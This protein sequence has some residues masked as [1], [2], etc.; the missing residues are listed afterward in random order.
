MNTGATPVNAGTGPALGP[1]EP[2][3]KQSGTRILAITSKAI[4]ISLL[5]LSLLLSA[6][7]QAKAPSP[8]QPIPDELLHSVILDTVAPAATPSYGSTLKPSFSKPQP[9]KPP[10]PPPK[11]ISP[12][13]RSIPTV[14]DAKRYA[15]DRLGSV[16]Y[17]CLANII[18]HEDGTWDPYRQN[19]SGSGAYGIPQALPGSKMASAGKDWRWNRITQVKWMISYVNRR[20]GSACQAWAYWQLHRWY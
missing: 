12:A 9:M 11:P 10:K 2:V 13:K 7:T 5:S 1:R 16:Q 3:P 15:L 4:R 19:M 17:A 20:Y 14:S 18:H 8:P 6:P